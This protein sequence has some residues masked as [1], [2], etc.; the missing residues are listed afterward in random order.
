MSSALEGFLKPFPEKI[1][2]IIELL[3]FYSEF[4]RFEEN[5]INKSFD[6]IYKKISKFH[7]SL[8]MMSFTNDE[9][10]HKLMTLIYL[11]A[12]EKFHS[13]KVPGFLVFCSLTL[14]YHHLSY[15]G[16][17]I[18]HKLMN[19]PTPAT[20]LRYERLIAK[21]MKEESKRMEKSQL[22]VMFFDNHQVI[23]LTNSISSLRSPKEF[24]IMLLGGG[25]SVPKKHLPA[26]TFQHLVHPRN[27]NIESIFVNYGL[28]SY[29]TNSLKNYHCHL[30]G[31]TDQ[32]VTYL[33][34]EEFQTFFRS[35]QSQSDSKTPLQ[36]FQ[37]ITTKYPEFPVDSTMAPIFHNRHAIASNDFTGVL[38]PLSISFG[39][40]TRSSAIDLINKNICQFSTLNDV[41]GTSPMKAIFKQNSSLYSWNEKPDIFKILIRNQITSA[42]SI[43]E[44][45]EQFCR[46]S[47]V[48]SSSER[49]WILEHPSIFLSRV[50]KIEILP[51]SKVN[52][53][54]IIAGVDELIY[55]WL[56]GEEASSV[57]PW[58]GE[59]HLI[60]NLS[61]KCI[62]LMNKIPL[63]RFIFSIMKI[64]PDCHGNI[65]PS[66]S[67]SEIQRT[68]DSFFLFG[69][70]IHVIRS[71]YKDSVTLKR[72]FDSN[73][74][75]QLEL[76]S[77]I[78]LHL[79]L[80]IMAFQEPCFELYLYELKTLLKLSFRLPT[81]LWNYKRS[82]ARHILNLSRL[83][84]K[85]SKT[86]FKIACYVVDKKSIGIRSGYRLPA[87][88]GNEE[89]I[90]EVNSASNSQTKLENL[91]ELE[92]SILTHF[93]LRSSAIK[94]FKGHSSPR[95]R[96]LYSSLS[97]SVC[98][99]RFLDEN[100]F[101]HLEN[102]NIVP[103]I[104][105]S[106][107]LRIQVS[108]LYA[109]KNGLW[110]VIQRRYRTLFRKE[111]KYSK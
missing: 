47:V 79:E 81:I 89:V 28:S 87:D 26:F 62:E 37:L 30:C 29:F 67:S 23:Q 74:W 8:G 53:K 50:K 16:C 24:S 27:L 46:G 64:T 93:F 7:S 33:N 41:S 111:L 106:H 84:L 20:I 85:W 80:L 88:F 18:L 22:G 75:K 109:L 21:S 54:G 110:E 17:L 82:I 12:S 35:V 103:I 58:L 56:V 108:C 66:K 49:K 69:R 39:Q 5:S 100:P 71:Y 99:L 38:F 68:I 11:L 4:L 77:E 83:P 105:E 34:N 25:A 73:S 107:A 57:F 70:L 42:L 52:F 97:L 31:F 72:I 32:I 65:R 45:L 55:N 10:E 51:S 15:A 92:Y 43:Q 90:F 3:T 78:A 76:F 40:P 6:E 61:K 2:D 14:K 86:I 102:T 91:V 9:R 96:R 94:I 95:H 13:W 63:A 60:Y 19:L 36:L 48:L 104:N 59:F 98:T 101:I 44:Y 1:P